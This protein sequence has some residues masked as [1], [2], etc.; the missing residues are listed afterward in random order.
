MDS[1]AVYKNGAEYAEFWGNGGKFTDVSQ[2]LKGYH[3]AVLE[4]VD[5]VG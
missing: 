5:G 4:Y 2:G 1:I 3:T